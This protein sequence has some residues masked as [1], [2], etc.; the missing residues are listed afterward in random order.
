MKKIIALFIITTVTFSCGEEVKKSSLDELNDQ[1]T[2]LVDKIDSLNKKLKTVEKKI[3]KLDLNKRLQMV[4]A[5]VVKNETFKHY[6]EIQG[7]VKADK[8]I[9]IR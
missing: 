5:L 8:N 7:V 1:R 3:S 6:V 2:I 9:E 4:T